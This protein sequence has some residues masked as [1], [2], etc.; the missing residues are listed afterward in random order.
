[1]NNEEIKLFTIHYKLFIDLKTR[2]L[3]QMREVLLPKLMSG[4]VRVMNNE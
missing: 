1:M 3:E 2:T 4:E